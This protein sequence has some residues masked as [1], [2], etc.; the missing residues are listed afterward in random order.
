[1]IRNGRDFRGNDL[2]LEANEITKQRL[3]E[4]GGIAS[5][6]ALHAEAAPQLGLTL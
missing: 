4:A 5:E 1:V 6:R 3:L 2:C